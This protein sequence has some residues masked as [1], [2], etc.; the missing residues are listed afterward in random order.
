[1]NYGEIERQTFRT[2]LAF[3][4]LL[5]V[6][7][8]VFF[9]IT[10][11]LYRVSDINYDSNLELNMSSLESLK[12][13]SIWLVDDTYFGSFYEENPS[14]ERI[15]I[16]K[17]LPDTLLV[18]IDISEKLAY[19]Q[20]NRQSPPRTFIL[21]KNLYTL[22]TRR[23]EDLTT[24]K[25]NNGPV[26]DGFLEEIVSLVMTLKKY[27]INLANV[28]A[29]Y[30]GESMRLSHFDSEFYLGYPSDLGRKAT[31]VGYY[32]SEKICTGE[33]RLVYSEDGKEI[34]AV[35]NCG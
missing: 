23:N 26:A 20:D 3:S 16:K 11:E 12:G 18:T 4:T 6:L 14:V 24:I 1:M 9:N 35:T 10:S 25:I 19:I 21:H 15:S 8:L 7:I 27:S 2:F 32:I 34:R 22:D 5:V 17:Q 30:D 33:I 13:T 28:E 29:F 31:V